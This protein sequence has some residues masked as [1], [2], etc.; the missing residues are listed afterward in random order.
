MRVCGV[1]VRGHTLLG[2]ITQNPL[3]GKQVAPLTGSRD[4]LTAKKEF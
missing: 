3:H 2:N 4:N 1:T